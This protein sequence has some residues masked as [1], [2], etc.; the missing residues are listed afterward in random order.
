MS[1]VYERDSFWWAY[2][3][4]HYSQGLKEIFDATRNFLW[5]AK[6]FFASKNILFLIVKYLA[7]FLISVI[8]FFVF[9]IWFLAPAILLGC[10]ILAF[11]FFIV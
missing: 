2:F 1:E 8:T 5:F 4:W 10:L 11:T 7:F 3:K 6:H 9:V